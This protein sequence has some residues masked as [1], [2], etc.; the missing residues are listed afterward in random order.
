M[1]SSFF[2]V[3]P[4][5]QK[6]PEQLQL[7]QEAA[8]QQW[9]DELPT[10]NPGLSTRL[11]VD[12]IKQSNKLEMGTE[13]RLQALESLRPIFLVM[14]DYLRSRLIK[15][16]FP[17]GENE[18]KIHNVLI[19]L[20]KEFAI[21]YW[22][23]VHDLTRKT[24]GWFKGKN[25]AMAI[26]RV[27][28][29]LSDIVIS[30]YLM[31]R[32]VP[33]WVWI[34]L[35]SLY[36]L[37]VKIKKEATKVSD[38]TNEFNKVSSIQDCYRQILLLS[39]ADPSGLMQ[40]EIRQVHQF[41]AKL[42]P[43]IQLGNEP[44]QGQQVQCIV[45]VDEDQPPLLTSSMQYKSDSA[46]IYIGLEKLF[47]TISRREK[48]VN[49]SEARFSSIHILKGSSEKLPTELLAYLEQ[50]WS[51]VP[52]Q[53]TPFF[54]D[55]LE[56]YFSIGLNSTH[57]L[58][59]ESD[60][61]VS[62]NIEYRA[63]SASETALSCKF[64]KTGVLSIGSMVSFRKVD[65][66]VNK[67][68]LGVVNKLVVSKKDGTINFEITALGAQAHS[69][70][71]LKLNAHKDDVPQ[72][73]LIYGLDFKQGQKSFLII[74]SF[75]FKEEDV[76]HLYLNNENFQIVLKDKK[77]VGLGYWQFECRQISDTEQ[78]TKATKKGYDFI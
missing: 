18:H 10:A 72:K 58:Q 75:M 48:F 30:H 46:T 67:R 47:K 6:S 28:K 57:E 20:E 60:Q 70:N 11:L 14:E 7:F 50:R 29:G 17:K 64:E 73:A 8:L 52:L 19:S 68:S 23:V 12:T 76:L 59:K 40:K 1:K 66:P 32:A 24:G 2:L 4:D 69:A 13:T 16:G 34:D 77:N 26:Q 45:L 38:V 35:H 78:S 37:G 53:G 5:Q 54:G 63:E 44:V 22:I 39:L 15:A 21:G 56:R 36:K 74:E 41:I 27:M 62:A 43:L 9:L 42:C 51:G 49:K 3:I 33:D 25:T 61:S 31:S 55:R 71:Y 65:M